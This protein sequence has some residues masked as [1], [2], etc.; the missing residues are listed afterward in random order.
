[1]NKRKQ[2][3]LEVLEQLSLTRQE[4]IEYF[5]S[6]KTPERLRTQINRLQ[7]QDT[8]VREPET[9]NR[10][11]PEAKPRRRSESNGSHVVNNHVVEPCSLAPL[12]G[13]T[14]A[15]H[16]TTFSDSQLFDEAKNSEILMASPAYAST[17]VDFPNRFSENGTNRR[18]SQESGVIRAILDEIENARIQLETYLLPV[19]TSS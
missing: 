15:V 18:F 11:R 9:H 4:W 1:M 12:G 14:F 7:G 10:P 2:L 8:P 17:D 13:E 6:K 19:M 5:K 16:D 3:S